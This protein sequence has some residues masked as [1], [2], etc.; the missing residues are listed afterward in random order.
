MDQIANRYNHSVQAP[1]G[2]AI[3]IAGGFAKTGGGSSLDGPAAK[4]ARLAVKDIN[5]RGSALGRHV[6]LIVRDSRHD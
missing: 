1:N 5:A 4:G 6:E 3:K 2:E